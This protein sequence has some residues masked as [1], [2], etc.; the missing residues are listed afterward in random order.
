[1]VAVININMAVA[2]CLLVLLVS[3]VTAHADTE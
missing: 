2:F 1:M 3:T